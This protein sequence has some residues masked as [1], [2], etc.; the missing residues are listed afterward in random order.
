MPI[1]P[2]L[3]EGEGERFRRY[4]R[5]AI[6]PIKQ[7]LELFEHDLFFQAKK[8]DQLY[9]DIHRQF[10]PMTYAEYG[11]DFFQQLVIESFFALP[12]PLALSEETFE[13]SAHMIRISA[14][15]NSHVGRP[16]PEG[17]HRDGYHYGSIH[18]MQRENVNGADNQIFDL[19]KNLID[20]SRLVDA[21]DSIYFDDSAIFHGV[22][23]FA[24]EN[25]LQRATRDML[26]LLYQPLKESPQKEKRSLML[27]EF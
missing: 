1:D 8:F 20:Q 15:P 2:H 12:I 9:G 19:N 24:A 27:R 7:T 6:N 3:F 4:A 10:A 13:V 21:M 18:L 5:F 22:T 14:T 17:I 25:C 23:P 26:I 16:A 11:N